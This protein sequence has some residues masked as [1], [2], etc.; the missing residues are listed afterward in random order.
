MLLALAAAAALL[1]PQTPD[2]E[3]TP[4]VVNPAASTAVICVP[5]YTSKPGVRHVTAA[6]KRA[7]FAEYGIDPKVGGP[8]EIDHLI[9]LELGGS[10]DI[11]NLWPQ[12]YAS[13]PYNAHLKD[14][15]EN[16]LHR[17]VCSGQ[18]SLDQAQK[19]ISSVWIGAFVK[20]VGEQ[21]ADPAR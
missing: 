7:V 11:R 18:V 9:S 10:N 15:L 2:P 19:A 8:Y 20:Y 12:S 17:L 13:Q 5:G 6:T 1:V 3:K 14:A 4:G 16:R 21:S